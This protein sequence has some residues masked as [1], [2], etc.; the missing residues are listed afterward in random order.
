MADSSGIIIHVPVLLEAS[1]NLTI[2][3]ETLAAEKVNFFD[4]YHFFTAGGSSS[5][6][7]LKA[8]TLRQLLYYM[9]ASGSGVN[10]TKLFLKGDVSGINLMNEQLKDVLVNSSAN[11]EQTFTDTGIDAPIEGKCGVA[12]RVLKKREANADVVYT[13]QITSD[14]SSNL[15]LGHAVLRYLATHLSG[16]PQGQAFIKNDEALISQV[17]GDKVDNSNNVGIVDQIVTELVKDLSDVS[18][19]TFDN[20]GY[21]IA[22]NKAGSN[23]VVLS[24]FEQ[25]VAQKP[26]RFDGS[27]N[28]VRPFPF[29]PADKIVVY[30]NVN[31]R[32]EIDT[33]P[34][35][36]SSGVIIASSIIPTIFTAA[37][38][39][40]IEHT[41][42]DA[43]GNND[44]TFS[45][46]NNNTN[47]DT[48]NTQRYTFKNSNVDMLTWRV[49]IELAED[50][51]S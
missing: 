28:V 4:S 16:N 2:F 14:V 38:Y 23:D 39:P 36:D 17:N 32:A 25:M 40:R 15:T 6:S 18:G 8:S 43:S 45:Y 9:D 35:V 50:D 1:G 49:D 10:E 13:S 26:E 29:Q 48:S 37:E 47:I 5:T 33:D 34:S 11:L 46:L 51:A 3:G 12:G 20:S 19:V 24:I 22:V 21:Q 42:L 41:Y 44:V 30:L 7:N 27:H 31:V